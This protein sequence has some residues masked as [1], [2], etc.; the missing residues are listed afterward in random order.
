MRVLTNTKKTFLLNFLVL[1][2]FT[3]EIGMFTIGS[4]IQLDIIA[5]PFFLVLFLFY[6]IT[7]SLNLTLNE[8][9]FFGILLVHGVFTTLFFEIP[10]I[11]FF[12][13]YVPILII[14]SVCKVIMT[15]HELKVIFE[16]YL[17]FSFIVALIGFVQLIL[18]FGGI[19]F[20]TPLHKF[21]IDSVAL[22][23][24]H[25]VC[26]VLPA[27]IYLYEKKDFNYKFYTIT[28]S[29][30]LTLKSTFPAAIFIYLLFKYSKNF[31]KLIVVF[32]VLF[33]VINNIIVFFPDAHERIS[34]LLGYF[35]ELDLSKVNNLTTFSLLSNL[36]V[37]VVNLFD[38]FGIGVGLGGHEATYFKQLDASLG[39]YGYGINAKSAH[40]LL[41]RMISE[42]PLLL[43]FFLFS[44][45]RKKDLFYKKSYYYI[46]M[47][48]L[49][50]FF[51]KCIK[52]GSYFDYGSIFFLILILLVIQKD[53]YNK[54]IISN[55]NV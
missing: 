21:Y 35:D 1:T 9:F 42:I 28:I 46:F 18:K 55:N 6:L 37:A 41:I 2:V 5:Y 26:L 51:V 32:V 45:L 36:E 22:E 38:S 30:I 27:A 54:L 12:K 39:Y 53:N 19:L 8:L 29:L 23:P 31:L 20:L 44:I 25:Y 47:A 49:S 52:L 17:F 33:Y 48:C 14:Y 43:L 34:S 13:Q 40:S 3:K 10:I 4:G 24:S 16:K 7:E 50:H 15:K 11:N